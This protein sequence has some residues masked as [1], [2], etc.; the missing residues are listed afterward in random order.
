MFFVSA[1]LLLK[2]SKD[3]YNNF[4]VKTV[5]LLIGTLVSNGGTMLMQQ[6]FTHYLPDGDVTLFSFISFATVAVLGLPAILLIKPKQNNEGTTQENK[7]TKALIIY[8]IALAVA[9][10]I[11]NQF[12]TLCTVLV[13]PVILFTFINGGGTIIST[14]VAA[15]LYKEK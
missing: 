9:L 5:L 13:S 1:F 2:S 12:A 6:M 15:I 11:I 10:F 8:G 4:S 14:I 3:T 7:L